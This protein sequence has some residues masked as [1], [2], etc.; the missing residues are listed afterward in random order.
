MHTGSHL[1]I[2]AGPPL[3]DESVLLTV[4]A[5]RLVNDIFQT[6][7]GLDDGTVWKFSS[8]LLNQHPPF[9]TT[10]NNTSWLSIISFIEL[11]FHRP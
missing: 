6:K 7:L 4:K 2:F 1:L 10:A 9:I 5:G 8:T 3:G 11:R